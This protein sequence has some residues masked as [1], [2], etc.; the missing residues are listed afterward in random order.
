MDS[1]S[2]KQ[3][4]PSSSKGKGG[5]IWYPFLFAVYPVMELLAHNLGQARADAGTR[6]ALAAILL[7]TFLM[8]FLRLLL[9]DWYRAAFV[10]AVWVGLF[11]AYGHVYQTLE[12]KAPEVAT[13][14]LLGGLSLLL[15]ALALFVASRPRVKMEAWKLPLDVAAIVLVIFPLGQILWYRVQAGFADVKL[16]ANE[17]QVDGARPD[18]YYIVLDMYTRADTMKAAYGYDNSEFLG[19]LEQM[20]FRVA[21]CSMA[22]YTRTELSL[23]SSLNMTYLTSDLDKR[24]NPD[25][26]AR[27]P[28][29]NLIRDNAAMEYVQARGYKTIAFS[30]GFPWSEL[31]NADIYYEPDPLRGGLT[32]FESLWLDT[33]AFRILEDKDVVD[34]RPIAFNRFRERT[35]FVLDTLPTLAQMD[36]PTFTFVHLILPHPPFVFAADGGTT[37]AVGF[38]NED[39]KYPKD[40]FAEGYTAQVTYANRELTRIIK[41][42]IAN[43]DTPP[44]IILQGDHGPWLQPK[45]RHMTILNAYYLPGHKD[46]IT[47]D[48]SPVNTFRIIFNLY[49]GGEFDLLENISYYSPVPKQYDF[50]VVP[51]A[52]R[53]R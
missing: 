15:V 2:T 24:I 9:R 48:M 16:P 38:L 31:D 8:G 50:S 13:V 23:S 49:L 42:I 11:A 53:P 36:E 37:D 33:T 46:T 29:W 28:L 12:K 34:V 22:N 52:C 47:A 18:I 51:N 41:E 21:E 4:H 45:D 44:V 26:I 17:I 14:N 30:T 20:G 5:F 19:G 1:K 10:A 27:S 32:E 40:K 6:A 43:S 25:S 35:L 39:E 3:K 7:T